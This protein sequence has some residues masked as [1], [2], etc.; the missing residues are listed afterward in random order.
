[1]DRK[2]ISFFKKLIGCKLCDIIYQPTAGILSDDNMF[3]FNFKGENDFLSLHVFAFARIRK[4]E[5]ILVMSSDEFFDENYN[6]ITDYS[7]GAF[8]EGTLLKKRIESIKESSKEMT[9][10]N[11]MLK[12]CGDLYV[13]F[14]NDM[15]LEIEIDCHYQDYEYYRLIDVNNENNYIVLQFK[16]EKVTFDYYWGREN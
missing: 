11:V 7:N 5:N 1:M 15:V 16:D 14:S 13:Y 4:R 6:K 9:V 12:S 3:V 2:L 10:K 8:L